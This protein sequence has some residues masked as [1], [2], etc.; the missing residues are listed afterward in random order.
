MID[1]TTDSLA[2]LFDSQ[3]K[4]NEGIEVSLSSED[5]EIILAMCPYTVLYALN[6]F[7][8]RAMVTGRHLE[9]MLS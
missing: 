4:I 3:L 7:Q 1:G 8:A 9:T 2:A 5:A 6:E